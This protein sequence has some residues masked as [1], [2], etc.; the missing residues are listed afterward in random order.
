[1]CCRLRKS[2]FETRIAD[3]HAGRV[4]LNRLA[5]SSSPPACDSRLHRISWECSARLARREGRSRPRFP[6]RPRPLSVVEEAAQEAW[7]E[8]LQIH[9]HHL[10]APNV[11]FG[12]L[13]LNGVGNPGIRD[14]DRKIPL[15]AVSS[16]ELEGSDTSLRGESN[17]C[18]Y[19]TI[20][21]GQK[22]RETDRPRSGR[23]GR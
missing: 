6:T 23:D 1:M 10:P 20:L 19:F 17:A 16:S 12:F 22:Q 14:R 2:R 9:V 11:D 7:D 5:R 18:F 4:S 13:P 8:P 21:A 15:G 3:E